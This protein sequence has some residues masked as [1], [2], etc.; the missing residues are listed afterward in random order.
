[1]GLKSVGVYANPHLKVQV[2]GVFSGAGVLK[3][4]DFAFLNI[5]KYDFNR[6]DEEKLL[7]FN[8]Y[9]IVYPSKQ[10]HFW[11]VEGWHI[12]EE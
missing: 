1:M 7:I 11:A 5:G 3:C 4:P 10:K 12:G 9:L 2:L 8:P 6:K